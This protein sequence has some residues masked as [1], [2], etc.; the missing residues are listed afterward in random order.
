MLTFDA[1]RSITYDLMISVI[2]SVRSLLS[3]PEHDWD[4]LFMEIY[5]FQ[6]HS[7]SW[8]SP[9]HEISI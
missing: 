7:N 6:I 1:L 9:H 4:Y 8:I 5:S 2:F 3:L